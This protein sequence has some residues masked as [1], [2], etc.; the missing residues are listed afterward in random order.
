MVM[1]SSTGLGSSEQQNLFRNALPNELRVR[2]GLLGSTIKAL[3]GMTCSLSPCI[4]AMKLS[5][6]GSGPMRMPGNSLSSRYRMKVVLPVE[7]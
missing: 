5:V 1:L 6:V 7:Y 2:N 4:T 3:P